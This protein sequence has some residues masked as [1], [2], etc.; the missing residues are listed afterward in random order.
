MWSNIKLGRQLKQAEQVQQKWLD[1]QTAHAQQL[2]KVS[3]DIRGPLTAVMGYVDLLIED[4]VKRAEDRLRC[5][6]NAK[7]SL[8]KMHEIIEMQLDQPA[9]N[10]KAIVHS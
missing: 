6:T 8:H 1:D 7:N 5:L 3:H 2:Q 4:R 9:Q 10:I